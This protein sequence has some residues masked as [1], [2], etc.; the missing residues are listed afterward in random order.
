[1]QY[2]ELFC[3]S[4]LKNIFAAIVTRS[5]EPDE[6]AQRNCYGIGA[7]IYSGLNKHK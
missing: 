6:E 2:I 1:V 5:S 3:D 7:V 4:E